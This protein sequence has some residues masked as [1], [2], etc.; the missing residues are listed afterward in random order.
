MVD[1]D[2]W[3]PEQLKS[4]LP[5]LVVHYKGHHTSK[6]VTATAKL[7]HRGEITS[8]ACNQSRIAGTCHSNSECLEIVEEILDTSIVTKKLEDSLVP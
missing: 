6:Q 7:M 3:Q 4:F 1:D 2:S 5:L 8:L